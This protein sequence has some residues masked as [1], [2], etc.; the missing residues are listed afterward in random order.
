ML[1][2]VRVIAVG[3]K[4]NLSRQQLAFGKAS[5]MS[6][7]ADTVTI[8]VSPNEA[9]ELIKA[10]AG[11]SNPVTLLLRPPVIAGD[12]ENPGGLVVEEAP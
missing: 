9:R 5:R 4:L 7:T 1:A 6:Q 12:T 10:T 3:N 11:G 2:D 8:E